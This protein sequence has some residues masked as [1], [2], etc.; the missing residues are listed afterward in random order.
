MASQS[1]NASSPG[2]HS[3]AGYLSK[4]FPKLS[5]KW[6]LPILLV[7]AVAIIPCIWHPEIEAGDLASHTYNAWLTSL[8]AKGKAPGLWIGHQTNN[9]LF[10]IALFRFTRLFGFAVGEKIAV[11]LTVLVFVWGVFA[12]AS[13]VAGRLAWFQLPLIVMLAYGWTLQMGF[14]NFYLSLGLSCIGLAVLWRANG[15][16]S[17]VSTIIMAALTW[18]AH[19]LGAVWFLGIAFYVIATRLTPQRTRWVIPAI[20]VVAIVVFRFW[21]A[22][23]YRVTWNGQFF[24]YNGSDQICLD[25]RDRFLAFSLLLVILAC[26]VLHLLQVRNLK[27]FLSLPVQLLALCFLGIGLLPDSIWLPQYAEPVSLISARFTLVVGILGCC[28]LAGIRPRILFAALMGVLALCFFGLLYRDTGKTYAMERQAEILVKQLPQDGRVVATIFPFR[29][30]RVF[31]HHIVDRACIEHCFVEDNYEAASGQFRLRAHPNNRIVA[32]SAE[33]TNRMMIGN[34]SVKPEDLPLWQIFQ[35]G[36]AEIDLCLRP[37]QTGSMLAFSPNGVIRARAL[38][39]AVSA[40]IPNGAP[41][42]Q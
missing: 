17:Y 13:V 15:A 36:P 38:G 4:H 32:A 31:V 8:A 7:S 18:V 30:S 42:G 21:L 37:L 9:V 20:G 33:D 40:A 11:C 22:A 27:G 12:L 16:F 24:Q 26:L 19:P 23:H 6:A 10:D 3:L 39:A 28:A 41:A 1:Y 25:A 34:Y 35:C 5:A 14:F 29:G 2:S